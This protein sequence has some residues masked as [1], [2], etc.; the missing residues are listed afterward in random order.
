MVDDFKQYFIEI[1]FEQIPRENNWVV[2]AMA[3]IASL[4]D[5]S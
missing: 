4:I 5:L 3:T 1:I 2:D